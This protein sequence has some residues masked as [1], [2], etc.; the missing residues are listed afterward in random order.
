MKETSYTAKEWHS[1]RLAVPRGPKGEKPIDTVAT[2]WNGADLMR[3]T[4]GDYANFVVSVMHDEGLTK[5]IAAERATMTRDL[6]KPEDLDKVCK[7]AGE[8]GHCTRPEWA[9]GGK[10]KP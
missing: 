1:G 10:S 5:E 3:T 2:T 7:V 4:I 6:V 8:V 9:W